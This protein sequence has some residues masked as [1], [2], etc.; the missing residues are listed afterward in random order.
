MV[1]RDRGARA[2]GDSEVTDVV[3]AHLDAVLRLDAQALAASARSIPS[4][5]DA[6]PT[7]PQMWRGIACAQPSTD[8]ALAEIEREARRV[9]ESARVI[10]VAAA[11]AMAAATRGEL[12]H[13][14]AF[15][16]RACRMARAEALPRTEQWV[17]LV[18]AR[19][20]RLTGQPYLA[21]RIVTALRQTATPAWRPWI[22]WELTMAAGRAGTPDPTG[23]AATLHAVLAHAEA[24][25]RGG[26]D[27]AIQHLHAQLDALA[28]MR[29]DARR[30]HAALDPTLAP[31][32]VDLAPWSTGGLAVEPPPLGLAGL[33]GPEATDDA[34]G[35]C[36]I[37]VAWPHRSGRRVLRAALGL[38]L[39][40]TGGVALG[41]AHVG[42]PEGIVAALALAGP[43]GMDEGAL[44]RAVYG[45]AYSRSIH[46]GAFDVALHRARELVDDH[47]EIARDHG[48]L[49]IV[50]RHAC[51]VPDPRSR[52]AADDRVLDQLARTGTV[53]ARELAAS[54]GMPLRTI[55][56]VLRSLVEDGACQPRRDGR[57]V[58]YSIEDTTFG[59]PTSA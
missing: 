35:G 25:D 57:H 48:H 43:Q 23:P 37:V 56:D 11:R 47:G 15:A 52:R 33:G 27:A 8:D 12:E 17:A 14:L 58:V 38:A 54:L 51:V 24:G 21:T 30:V 53:G 16:R 59:E 3:A 19:L 40:H 41:G 34:A 18:L 5:G 31:L 39:E 13:A 50:L 1:E 9:G 55:Q 22:D 28:P 49:R 20:R 26:F 36:A 45:F 10:E 29:D 32:E 2:P 7:T 44:F 4:S 42:R 6:G 46:R